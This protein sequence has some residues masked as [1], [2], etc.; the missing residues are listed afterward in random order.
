MDP[1]PRTPPVVLLG[2]GA[3]ALGASP[4]RTPGAGLRPWLFSSPFSFGR[5][6]SGSRDSDSE[7]DLDGSAP[8][9]GAAARIHL[10]KK[11]TFRARLRVSFAYRS[12][13]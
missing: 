7:E 8:T 9:R 11:K 2:T 10:V 12:R 13:S 4:G 1:E 3:G 5:G 6:G